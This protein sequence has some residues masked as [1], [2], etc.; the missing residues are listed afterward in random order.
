MYYLLCYA[1]TILTVSKEVEELEVV[2]AIFYCEMLVMRNV[3]NVKEWMKVS[4]RKYTGQ[5]NKTLFA[6][7]NSESF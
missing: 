6:I 3:K 5:T 1:L 2:P 4:K 7:I